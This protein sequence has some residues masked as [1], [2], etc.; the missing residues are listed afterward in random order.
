[1]SNRTTVHAKA[2]MQRRGGK[3]KERQQRFLPGNPYYIRLARS[4]NCAVQELCSSLTTVPGRPAAPQPE[5]IKHSAYFV[6]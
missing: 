4:G 3:K 6:A 1:M 5:S 2:T